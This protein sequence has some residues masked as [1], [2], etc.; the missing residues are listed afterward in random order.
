MNRNEKIAELKK[1]GIFNQ[2]KYN[3]EAANLKFNIE[4]SECSMT[5]EERI[6][7]LLDVDC[8][9]QRFIIISFPFHDTLEGATFWENIVNK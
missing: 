9:F 3:V 2:W 4:C 8:S 7:G 6:N 5:N 1:I